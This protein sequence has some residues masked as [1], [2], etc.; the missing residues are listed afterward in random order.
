M[1]SQVNRGN[2]VYSGEGIKHPLSI[3]KAAR[4]A[5]DDDNFVV[6]IKKSSEMQITEVTL[7]ATITNT[8]TREVMVFSIGS[9]RVGDHAKE[10]SNVVD[11]F[12]ETLDLYI[13]MGE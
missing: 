4:A 1:K 5:I 8:K 2:V 6:I 13:E 11:E 3:L 12:R 10:K 9:L 7:D